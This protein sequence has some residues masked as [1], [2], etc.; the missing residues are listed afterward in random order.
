M[1]SWRASLAEYQQRWR[2][3]GLTLDSC[4]MDYLIHPEWF[5]DGNQLVLILVGI[6]AMVVLVK[7][8]DWL[9]NGATDLALRFGIPEVIIGATIVSLGT[10][11]PE[12]AVSVMAAFSDK[13]GLALGNGVGSIIA[14]TGL[15]F[16]LGCMLV[17]L[18]ADR[19]ILNRQGWVQFGS[20]VLLAAL[21]YAVWLVMGDEAVLGRSIGVL[22]L[23]LLAGYLY[24]S[25]RWGRQ[26]AANTATKLPEAAETTLKQPPPSLVK[27]I[28]MGF[29]GLVVVIISSDIVVKCVTDLALQWGVPEVT[30]ASTIV[31]FGTSL[32]E[33][34]VGMMALKKGHPE[35][36]LGNVIGADILNVLFVIGASATATPLAIVDQTASIPEMFLYLQLPT[37]LLMLLWFRFVIFK[38]VRQGHFTRWWGA[39]LLILYVAFLVLNALLGHVEP[40][41]G[42]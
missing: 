31:A 12:A 18:P 30:I 28:A 27:T 23:A 42:S 14:D 8:A 16:G 41:A 36:L 6:T 26:H 32:P 10:T 20:A 7:G 4:P 2:E 34:V 33:L 35:L 25:V 1:F 21:A 19:F 39:P 37:M 9:V 17:V 13:P 3:T 24:L 5:E 11:S 22:F 38:A 15:I 29:A 40:G